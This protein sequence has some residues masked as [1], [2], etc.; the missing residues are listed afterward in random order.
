MAARARCISRSM[1]GRWISIS[2][3]LLVTSCTA[4]PALHYLMA[5]DRTAVAAHE[6]DLLPYAREQVKQLLHLLARIG[7]KIMF[8]GGYRRA[9]QRHQ[10]VQRR[11]GRTAC[12]Q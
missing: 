3:P 10:I 8:M 4:P 2:T 11:W 9:V 12:D 5:L 1:C 7:Q 6:H